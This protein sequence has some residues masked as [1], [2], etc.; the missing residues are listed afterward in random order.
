MWSISAVSDVVSILLLH[1][2]RYKCVYTVKK[3]FTSITRGSASDLL[4]DAASRKNREKC[5]LLLP[6]SESLARC[7]ELLKDFLPRARQIEGLKQPRT[8]Q[9]HSQS[10]R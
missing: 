1:S 9:T 4:L 8:L 6:L 2:E 3:S 10:V 5:I 7:H